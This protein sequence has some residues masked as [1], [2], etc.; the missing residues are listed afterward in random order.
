MKRWERKYIFVSCSFVSFEIIRERG[1]SEEE[2]EKRQMKNITWQNERLL[3]G[4][5]EQ[6][7]NNEK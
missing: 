2:E 5:Y 7:N 4:E 3:Y 1:E 6:R